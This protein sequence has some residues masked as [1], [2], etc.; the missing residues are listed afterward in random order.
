MANVYW[1]PRDKKP[2]GSRPSGQAVETH[3]E[4]VDHGAMRLRYGGWT[5]GLEVMT[6]RSG[7][8]TLCEYEG[9]MGRG[10]RVGVKGVR[11]CAI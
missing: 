10:R 4:G 11:W 7:P 5:S 1:E 8:G 3:D 6:R 9:R 2:R